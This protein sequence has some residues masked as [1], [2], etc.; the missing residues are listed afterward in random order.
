MS[1]GSTGV[2]KTELSKA[3]T[4]QLFNDPTAMIRI[5]MSEYMEKHSVSRLIGAP[6]GYVGYSEGGLL[7]EAVKR[8][9]YQVILLDEFEK[10]HKDVSN[11]LLQVFDE[12]RLTD[13][14]GNRVDFRNTIIILTSNLG[15][16]KIYKALQ[17][18]PAADAA[19]SLSDPDHGEKEQILL[20]AKQ[21]FQSELGLQVVKSHFPPEFVNR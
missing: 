20:S 19:L 11:I 3:I 5:D 8:R 13:S 4:E 17:D 1:V 15:S 12:G 10:A 16:S 6:P 18:T 9:P 21:Q 7:T 2:G 14:L